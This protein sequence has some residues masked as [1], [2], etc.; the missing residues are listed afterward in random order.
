M[1][2]ITLHPHATHAPDHRSSVRQD[3]QIPSKTED[4]VLADLIIFPVPINEK[5][6]C[7]GVGIFKMVA[8]A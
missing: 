4:T 8:G 3:S 1:E 5:A 7:D 2:L 6:D